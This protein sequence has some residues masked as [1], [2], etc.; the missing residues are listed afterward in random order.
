MFRRSYIHDNK[1]AMVSLAAFEVGLFEVL[2]EV[3]H[4]TT[5]QTHPKRSSSFDTVQVGA[6]GMIPPR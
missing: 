1:H 6:L 2:S 3:E 5:H 4:L